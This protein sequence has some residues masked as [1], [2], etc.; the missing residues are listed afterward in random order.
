MGTA[1]RPLL[2]AI[3]GQA[4]SGKTATAR[5]LFERLDDCALLDMDAL[6]T[7]EP[8][9]WGEALSQLG[10]RNAAAVAANYWQAGFTQVILAGGLCRQELVDYMLSLLPAEATLH[11]VWL[12]AER[13][14]RHA[15]C[16]ARAR[17]GADAHEHLAFRDSLLPYTGPLR[18]PGDRYTELETTRRTPEAVAQEIVR[19]LGSEGLTLRKT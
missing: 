3:N 15:R 14:V 13:D 12:Q 8:F 16:L 18:L 9:V 1:S 2:I 5:A 19:W 7:V 4:G 10:L 17:D 6:T 11:L